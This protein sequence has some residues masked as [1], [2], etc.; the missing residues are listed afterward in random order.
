MSSRGSLAKKGYISTTDYLIKEIT[1]S[2]VKIL[3]GKKNNHSLPELAHTPNSVYAKLKKDGITLLELRFFDE[4][5]LTIFEIGY[6]PESKINNGNRKDNI[7]H[8]HLFEGL[9]RKDA[10]KLNQYPEIKEKYKKYLEECNL[11]DK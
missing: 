3:E 10:K 8:F 2:G 4:K 11:Y 7:L 1:P 6:H 5:G 9:I